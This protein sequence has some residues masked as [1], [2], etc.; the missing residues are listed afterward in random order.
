[1]ETRGED[2]LK[3]LEDPLIFEEL[4]QLIYFK[5][6]LSETLRLYP[7]MLEDSK[8]VIADDAL[9]DGT[10]VPKG[11]N[12]TFSIYSTGRM[13]FIW[14]DDCL[15]FK[16]ERWLSKDGK[17]FEAKYQF[18]FVAFHA[19][20]RIWLDKDLAYLQMKSIAVAVLLRHR[21][22]VAPRHKVEQ[23]TSLT[24]FMK[25]GLKVNVYPRVLIPIWAKIGIKVLYFFS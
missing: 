7:L 20:P 19:G 11:S 5:A 15:E 2:T 17:K 22:M 18:Q 14:G 12:I 9:L 6:V 4:Y 21:L 10:F 8:H 13:K 23:K 16:P 3:W 24:L 25:Y 1:M